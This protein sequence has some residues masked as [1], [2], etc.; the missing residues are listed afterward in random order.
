MQHTF[1]NDYVLMCP[2]SHPIHMSKPLS[3]VLQN[4]DQVFQEVIT[5]EHDP[6]RGAL[7]HYDW[8]PYEKR[9]KHQGCVRTE[10]TAMGR[11]S[12]ETAVC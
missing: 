8:C 5:L 10:G 1:G 6:E 9:Q 12:R 3:P 4:G 7:S 2:P 11:G